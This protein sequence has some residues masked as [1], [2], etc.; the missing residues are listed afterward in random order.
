[1]AKQ[2]IRII[3]FDQLP[4]QVRPT[5]SGQHLDLQLKRIAARSWMRQH[6]FAEAMYWKNLSRFSRAIGNVV[7]LEDYQ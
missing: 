5:T 1:M 7:R 6:P 3:G 2:A 4:P